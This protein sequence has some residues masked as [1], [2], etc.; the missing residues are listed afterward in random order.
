MSKTATEQTHQAWPRTLLLLLATIAW[1]LFWYWDTA[2]AMVA[3]WARSD[4]YAHAF[5]VP[6]I[7]LW[8]IW[9]KRKELALLTPE[10]TLWFIL[11]IGATAFFWLMGE[12]TAVNALTQ[13]ALVATLILAIISILGP[14]VS[15]AIAFPLAF[16]LLS[17]PVGDFML[18]K[19]MEWTAWFTILALRASGI[20]VYQEG[21]QFVIP[22]GNWSV[23]EACSGIRY[24]IASVT[25]GTLFA[26]L[27][28]VSLRRRLIFIAISFIVP[29]FANW[30]RAYMIV[31]I[32]HL[33]GIQAGRRRRSPDLW[34]GLLRHR[35]HG[36]V[37]D[38]RPV[39]RGSAG[40][41]V[42]QCNTGP[43][44]GRKIAS[45]ARRPC[46][47]SGNSGWPTCLH[48]HYG[49]RQGFTRQA[50]RI[51][52]ATRMAQGACLYRL[53][54]R[55]R[56][57]FCN[58]AGNFWRRKWESWHLYWLL[59]KPELRAQAD[60]LYQYAGHQQRQNLVRHLARLLPDKS[61]R[62]SAT[63]ANRRN[64]QQGKWP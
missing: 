51:A 29:V 50:W 4:T 18:P 8:L 49:C 61:A 62:R 7:S 10:P 34:L 14:R 57:I 33:S 16:L 36:D 30:L 39:E 21:L 31:M 1:V 13:F 6:P 26:Y 27:N 55:L 45:M 11:P 19:L 63:G 12:L 25:V 5:V 47:C 32:G 9:R 35:D 46:D 17:V 37:R 58:P 2:Q 23:V 43:Q 41:N 53:E 38:R 3:I 42:C 64:P 60:Y 24:I 54:A 52:S 56:G 59:S 22:S 44:H 15:R 40:G 28:Y 48:G 20:P